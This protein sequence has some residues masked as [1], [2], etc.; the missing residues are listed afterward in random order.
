[1]GGR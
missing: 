1:M